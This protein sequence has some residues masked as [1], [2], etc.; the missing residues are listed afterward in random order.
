MP[1]LR[2]QQEIN[3]KESS[4]QVMCVGN[5]CS[6]VHR[7]CQLFDN[8]GSSTK[9]TTQQCCLPNIYNAQSLIRRLFIS[10]PPPYVHKLKSI[11]PCARYNP[12]KLH[13][14]WFGPPATFTSTSTCPGIPSMLQVVGRINESKGKI[15]NDCKTEE[16]AQHS[17]ANFIIET[18]LPSLCNLS[19]S[20]P[21]RSQSVDHR[22]PCSHG[23]KNR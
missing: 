17:R 9:Y 2:T 22:V 16:N 5:S 11:F 13:P 15:D 7:K 23:E 19:R 18:T 6:V 20:P 10:P 8:S 12:T 14:R 21:E 3:E 1:F 4:S